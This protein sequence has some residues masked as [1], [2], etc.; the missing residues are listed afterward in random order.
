MLVATFGPTTAW[1]GKTITFENGQFVLEGHGPI[2]APDVMEH[3]RRGHLAWVDDGTRAWV[4]AR[5]GSLS[6][7]RP[8][9]SDAST[10]TVAETPRP[11]WPRRTQVVTGALAAVAVILVAVLAF[12][13]RPDDSK[14]TAAKAVSPG[15]SASP[16]VVATYATPPAAVQQTWPSRFQGSWLST[17]SDNAEVG[18]SQNVDTAIIRIAPGSGTWTDLTFHDDTLTMTSSDDE[19]SMVYK[20]ASVPADAFVG[21]YRSTLSPDLA[22][23]DYIYDLAF[24]G[25]ALTMTIGKQGSAPELITFSLQN[26]GRTMLVATSGSASPGT[27]TFLR[28]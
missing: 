26:D 2:S 9:A 17:A 11:R 8:E 27:E 24:N 20:C 4:G 22:T 23:S 15:A 13:N 28:Q 21:S 14:S 10:A 5:A 19:R 16:T 1:V 6:A 3:D 12:S 25:S 7:L 18:F